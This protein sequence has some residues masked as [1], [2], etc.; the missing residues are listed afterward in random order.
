MYLY[1]YI[2]I[3]IYIHTYRLLSLAPIHVLVFTDEYL[4]VLSAVAV[5]IWLDLSACSSSSLRLLFAFIPT[6]R[7]I[8]A[9]L[10]VAGLIGA[11]LGTY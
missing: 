10:G 4:L 9:C 1:R 11:C 8:G 3:Y 7:L 6:R 2:Y 5:I